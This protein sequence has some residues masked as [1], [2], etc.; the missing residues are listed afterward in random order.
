MIHTIQRGALRLDLIHT[1]NDP[2]ADSGRH[3]SVIVWIYSSLCVHS[4]PTYLPGLRAAGLREA[5]AGL[6]TACVEAD[7]EAA[8]VEARR[9]RSKFRRG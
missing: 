4:E 1:I 5:E 6:E 2:S 9:H 7:L 3:K 8:C